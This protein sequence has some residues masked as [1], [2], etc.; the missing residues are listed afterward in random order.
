MT[1]REISEE[2]GLS[3]ATVSNVIHGHLEKM[4]PETAQ[5]IRE[6]LEQYQYVP[7]MGA[8]MLA[9][10]GS[11]IIGVIFCYP[12][13]EDKS[14]FQDSFVAEMLGSLENEIRTHGYFMMP[15]VARNAEEICRVAQT[16]NTGGLV[17]WG[18]MP[19]ECRK[20]NESIDKPLVFVDCYFESEK[21][22]S[23][24]GSDD[25]KGGYLMAEHM[26]KIGHKRIAYLCDAEVP[27]G[28]DLHR[29]NGHKAAMKKA[30]V[31]WDDSL[32]IPLRQNR[33]EQRLRAND[34]AR[35]IKEK[36]LT[37]LCFASDYYAVIV[38]D[39]LKELGIVIPDDCAVGG[40]DD[41][42]IASLVRPQLTTIHQN[43]TEKARTA[44][45][46]VLK[47]IEKPKTTCQTKRQNVY[48]VKRESSNCNK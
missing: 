44:A 21:P 2:L 17:V 20:L 13:R 48:L 37:A 4:S 27:V 45:T 10:G 29:L 15:Y 43:V 3:T 5:T 30:G 35:R 38:M 47:Q 6:K 19:E 12:I 40:Y 34:I 39:M 41:A 9:N 16:W 31:L 26:L 23:N 14:A 18:I 32:F 22:F 36:D 42:M 24:V 11:N 28:V 25:F 33:R 46:M 7:N 8:R 1:I